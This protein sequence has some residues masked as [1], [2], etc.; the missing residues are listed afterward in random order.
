VDQVAD[1]LVDHQPE[2]RSDWIVDQPAAQLAV[3]PV[4]WVAEQVVLAEAF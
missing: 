3:R 4:D 1:R 2:F